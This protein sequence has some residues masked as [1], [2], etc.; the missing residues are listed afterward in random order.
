MLKQFNRRLAPLALLAPILAVLPAGAQ[1]ITEDLKIIPNTEDLQFPDIGVHFGNSVSIEGTTAMIGVPRYDGPGGLIFAGAAYLYDIGTGQQISQMMPQGL[2]SND[3]FGTSVAISG[4]IA[5]VG[6]PYDSEG[7]GSAGAAYLFDAATGQQLF[8]LTASDAES[9]DTFGGA[10][11][12]AGGV[13][14]VGSR[15]DDDGVNLSGAAYI[16]DVA[17]GQQLFK[18]AAPD[19][20]TEGL[21]GQS[22]A[23]SGTTVLVGA[24]RTASLGLGEGAVY[25]FNASTGTYLRTL[26]PTDPENGDAFGKSIAVSGDTAIVGAQGN[27][28]DGT[29]SGSVYL[30]D[31]NTGGQLHKLTAS[32]AG[33]LAGFGTSVSISG[34]T[35]IIGATGS[36]GVGP[37]TGAAYLFDITTGVEGFK[38]IGSD[39]GVN[40]RFG[41][42]VAFSGG[43]A[44][45]GAR[46]DDEADTDAG[47]A[48]FFQLAPFIQQQ[49]GSLVVTAGETAELT[50]AGVSLSAVQYQWR[51]DGIDL[52]DGGN[53]SGA[54]APT[55]SI[56]T[57]PDD[58]GYYDC[59][60]TNDTGS[61][62][63]NQ[64][65][66]SVRPDPN[67]CVADLNGD[68]L[69]NFFDVSVFLTA[70]G[71]GCP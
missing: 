54:Q 14:V 48:Y 26:T 37:S 69:L 28:D 53:I 20:F 44:V 32:D 24:E 10:V 3:G 34:N 43:I 50:T 60:L 36:A 65:V 41:H 5:I 57:T 59:V 64:V 42:S 62:T 9:Q 2:N 71:A 40:D 58:A 15:G 47:A 56:V 11:A 45:V 4:G 63:T 68:G 31:I 16:F 6:A 51:R 39:G 33:E 52:N 22:V 19:P 23:I 21:F 46:D 7:G 27:D 13:A 12:I 18:L 49:P 1:V 29:N 55:L 8:K 67:A 25:V 30:F 70:Y 38:L 61:A 35:A 17:T 66:L